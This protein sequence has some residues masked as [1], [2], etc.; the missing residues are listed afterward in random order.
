MIT[1]PGAR[2]RALLIPA[3]LLGLTSVTSLA[4][5][6]PAAQP[7][8][9]PA[10]SNTVT[11]LNNLTVPVTIF[12]DYG[13]Y[14]RRLGTIAPQTS[15]SL[16]LPEFALKELPTL[17]LYAKVEQGFALETHGFKVV[18]DMRVGWVVAKDLPAKAQGDTIKVTP[19][20]PAMAKTT[21][22]VINERDAMVSLYAEENGKP[23]VKLGWVGPKG[24]ATVSVPEALVG[25]N[26][27]VRIVAHAEGATDLPAQ[28]I[29]LA[30]ESVDLKISAG[31][32]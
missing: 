21:L 28:D 20:K 2:A 31:A 15:A 4:A 3:L 8:A 1:T 32:E 26:R 18:P 24:R 13:D 17:Q 25:P 22:A 23:G 14:D 6:T 27:T 30:G 11:V 12:L 7:A 16:P 19:A 9:A 29:G 5:Q 10:A